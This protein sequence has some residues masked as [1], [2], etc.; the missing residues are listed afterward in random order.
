VNATLV[1][2]PRFP[3]TKS[4]ESESFPPSF[5]FSLNIHIDAL[6]CEFHTRSVVQTSFQQQPNSESLVEAG[7]E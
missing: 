3:H 5:S 2:S 1:L 6:M 7:G 4:L